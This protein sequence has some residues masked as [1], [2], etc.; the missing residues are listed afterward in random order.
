MDKAKEIQAQRDAENL[1]NHRER[2]EWL[3]G[4][5]PCWADGE[6][7]DCHTRQVLLLQ[8]REALKY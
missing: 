3:E 6:P 7:V 2:I 1:R 5:S 4:D 8:S